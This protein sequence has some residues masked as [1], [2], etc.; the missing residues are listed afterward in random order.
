MK[1]LIAGAMTTVAVGAMVPLF[2]AAPANAAAHSVEKA[3]VC[4]PGSTKFAW[5]LISKKPTVTHGLLRVAKTPVQVAAKLPQVTA[6]KSV[7]SGAVDPSTVLA[8]LEKQTKLKLAPVKK[9]TPKSVTLTAKLTLGRT[10][11][12]AGTTKAG[13][14]YTA[15]TCNGKGTAYGKT[16]RG[17]AYSWTTLSKGAINC[18]TKT[19]NRLAGAA[20]NK[21]C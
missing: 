10:A 6:V 18:K 15:K 4:K 9:A 13:G 8:D 5:Q 19:V 3:R 20:Q 1:K 7:V 16:Q 2:V 11:L 12:Y 21:F 14:S 17:Y